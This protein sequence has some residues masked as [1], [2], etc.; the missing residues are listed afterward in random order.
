M[1]QLGF[2]TVTLLTFLFPVLLFYR[3]KVQVKSFIYYTLFAFGWIT[4]LLILDSSGVLLD[5]SLPPRIPLLIV[6]P[7]LI[8][9]FAF[10]R[11]KLSNKLLKTTPLFFPI[12]LQS[13]RIAVEILL[14]NASQAGIIPKE[15]TFEGTNMDILVGLSAPV[16]A[17]LV[18]RQLITHKILYIWNV[19]S[20]CVLFVTVFSF[21][22]IYFFTDYVARTGNMQFAEVPY[23]FLPGVLVPCA[24]FL[25]AFSIRQLYNK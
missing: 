18:K 6:L 25:H 2:I 20:L 10:L 24:V 15:T 14:Y 8:S 22:H 13:F 17:Y 16:V 4:Y 11:S 1:L 12:L 3:A 19:G 5:F 7:A 21:V 23:I 9:V